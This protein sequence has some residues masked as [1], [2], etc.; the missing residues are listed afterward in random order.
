MDL[1]AFA[2]GGGAAAVLAALGVILRAWRLRKHDHEDHL[3]R[4]EV[5]RLNPSAP[6]LENLAITR[7]AEHIDT[8]SLKR[9]VS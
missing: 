7:R 3:L 5:L 1:G 2:A 8:A 9:R 4:L 6:V